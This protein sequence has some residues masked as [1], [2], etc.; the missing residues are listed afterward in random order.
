MYARRTHLLLCKGLKTE[1]KQGQEQQQGESG[2]SPSRLPS[3]AIII[4]SFI[5]S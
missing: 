3:S 4:R 5:F 1:E 2:T